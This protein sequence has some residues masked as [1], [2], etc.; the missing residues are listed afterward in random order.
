MLWCYFFKTQT[1]NCFSALHFSAARS[2][3]IA[4][5]VATTPQFTIL[6]QAATAAGLVGELADPTVQLTVFAPTD[7]AFIKLLTSLNVSPEEL[8]MDTTL[9]RTILL[10]TLYIFFRITLID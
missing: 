7:E 10:S 8:L 1:L 6:A 5:T 2:A 4:D 3:T 9:L